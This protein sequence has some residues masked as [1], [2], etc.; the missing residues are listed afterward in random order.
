MA[1]D[2][3]ADPDRLKQVYRA[4]L[5]RHRENGWSLAGLVKSLEAQGKKLETAQARQQFE[6]AWQSA[7]F[8]L[9]ASRR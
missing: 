6:K 1:D 9:E 4:D 2:P 7:D 3:L 8:H 5:N